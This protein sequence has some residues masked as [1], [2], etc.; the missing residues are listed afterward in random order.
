MN[1]RYQLSEGTTTIGRA[2][3]DYP[4]DISVEGDDAM[5]RQSVAII[6]EDDG[7]GGYDYRLKVLNATNRVSVN[8]QRVKQGD[9]TYLEF[10]DMIQM[11]K[12]KFKFDNH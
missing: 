5:S 10:G 1:R 8:G 7:S 4:S 12:T 2:D 6:I 9:E 11:G 3:A